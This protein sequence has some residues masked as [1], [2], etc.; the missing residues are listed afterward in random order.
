VVKKRIIS[1]SL[2]ATLL[3][4][5]VLSIE[6][7]NAA[8]ST[9]VVIAT[10]IAFTSLNPYTTETYLNINR[11]IK[12]LT[13]TGFNYING[14][15]E[16]VQNKS[17]GEYAVIPPSNGV[18]DYQVKYVWN[19]NAVW[20]D[21][22]P[23]TK[24]DFLFW[25]LI[26]SNSY[27][28]SAGLGSPN[29]SAVK[30]AFNSILYG[31]FPDEFISKPTGWSDTHITFGYSSLPSYW[32]Y[33]TPI[34]FPVHAIGMYEKGLTISSNATAHLSTATQEKAN[35]YNAYMKGDTATLKKL[36]NVWSNSY[37]VDRISASTNPLLLVC[38]GAYQVN[39]AGNDPAKNVRLV[40]NKNY[41][42]MAPKI[43]RIDFAL[44][45][46][47]E[48]AEQAL[49]KGEI[50]ILGLAATSEVVAKYSSKTGINVVP[51]D[52]SYIEH[53]YI[54][55]GS[56]SSSWST[57]KPL[58]GASVQAREL[59][60][61]LLMALPRQEVVDQIIKPINRLA[62]VPESL[63]VLPTDSQYLKHVQSSNVGKYSPSG[64]SSAAKTAQALAIVKKYFPNAAAD[65]PAIPV[66][67]LYSA[68]NNRRVAVV[69]LINASLSKAGFQV[70][71]SPEASWASKLGDPN[72]DAM[73]FGWTVGPLYK[74]TGNIYCTTCG[75]NFIGL[76][77]PIID[78]ATQRLFTVTSI[79]DRRAA[80][81]QI[82]N[83]VVSIEAASLPIYVFPVVYAVSKSLNNFK[84]TSNNPY[85]AIWNFW[86]WSASAVS[87]TPVKPTSPLVTKIS[88]SDG[89]LT[90]QMKVDAKSSKAYAYSPGLE[91][92]KSKPLEGEIKN[93]VAF[94]T[95]PLTNKFSGQSVTVAAYS[96]ANGVQSDSTVETV[97]V[98]KLS[99]PT[100]TASK[101][102]TPKATTKKPAPVATK[103]PTVMCKKPGQTDRPRIG[104]EC[105]KGW[106]EFRQ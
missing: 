42:G 21:G 40:R 75:N 31:D 12:Y 39:E 54:R 13:S 6:S 61:A 63:L 24:E 55:V 51:G 99:T 9:Q 34:A 103:S 45:P 68:I 89:V 20:S 37:N 67:I 33:Y 86:E 62:K 79:I 84:L 104:A 11:D 73:L 3:F 66:R 70:I 77:N 76:S 4:G 87:T 91:I 16:I 14:S 106:T 64:Q 49:D 32:E 19:K 57:A 22:V 82:E 30:P 50:D 7:T 35:F 92:L 74:Q 96:I 27:S 65:R 90:I 105:I 26:T 101:S 60:S 44:Y 48:K 88:T 17:F 100:P 29:D 25:H 93:G 94:F 53:F 47:A 56:S 71:E 52:N 69:K 59:R 97:R 1:L 83:Q 15:G 58:Q 18:S 5:S 81:I 78:S 72:Y 80:L 38:N 41:T 23:I 10:P 98:P 95:I 8:T 102:P 36:G 28:I 85:P 43:V 2:A 46:D